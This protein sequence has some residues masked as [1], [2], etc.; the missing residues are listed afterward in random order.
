MA[1]KD[2]AVAAQAV[3][4]DIVVIK[5]LDSGMRDYP[6]LDGSSV[7]LEARHKGVA[8][9]EIKESLIS[10]ALRTAEKNGHVRIIRKGE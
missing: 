3:A 8:W 4:A 5:N 6:L 10:P 9:P 2:E 7:Y 1:K